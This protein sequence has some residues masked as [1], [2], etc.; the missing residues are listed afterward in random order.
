MSRYEIW[1][2]VGIDVT[3]I[4]VLVEVYLRYC[5][6]CYVVVVVV[7][8]EDVCAFV[9]TNVRTIRGIVGVLCC[10]TLRQ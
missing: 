6:C 3:E 5:C 7:V 4:D 8:I 1:L 2:L 9:V 10:C